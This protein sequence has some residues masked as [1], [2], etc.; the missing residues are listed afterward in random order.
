MNNFYMGA[1]VTCIVLVLLEGF[2]VIIALRKIRDL[3][4][5]KI[6]EDAD[7]AVKKLSDTELVSKLNSELKPPS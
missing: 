7:V 3:Q 5:S 4:I 1:W 6:Q 2:G